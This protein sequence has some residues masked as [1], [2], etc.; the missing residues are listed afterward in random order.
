MKLR[1]LSSL[2][3]L[4]FSRM[5]AGCPRHFELPEIQPANPQVSPH[6]Q[7]HLE[8]YSIRSEANARLDSGAPRLTST[9]LFAF[10]RSRLRLE[11][12]WRTNPST[13]IG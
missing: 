5:S 13:A 3:L 8:G 11:R 6:L 10:C 12:G 2:L 1:V 9:R 4:S 7:S